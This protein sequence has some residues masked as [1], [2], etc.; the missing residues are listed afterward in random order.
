[1]NQ[2]V[3]F[4]PNA[5]KYMYAYNH[6]TPLPSQR[7]L[8][9]MV[10][11]NIYRN[12]AK[13]YANNLTSNE[14]VTTILEDTTE[15]WSSISEKI[16]GVA[17]M[18]PEG[19]YN[20]STYLG[21]NKE[22]MLPFREALEN[23]QII[24]SVMEWCREEI[25]EGTKSVVRSEDPMS[26]KP[27][28]QDVSFAEKV[29]LSDENR[30]IVIGDVHGGLHTFVEI[31]NSLYERGILK[32]DFGL[33]KGYHVIFLG[34]LVDRGVHSLDVL[35]LVFRLKTR[36]IQSVHIINGNHEDLGTYSNYGFK[37]ELESQ[38]EDEGD[39]DIV[40]NLL[41]YLPTV[42]FVRISNKWIQF[43]H[44][45]ID[46]EYN[47]RKF[48]VSEFD[49]EYHGYDDPIDLKY[50]GLRW[51]DFN[52]NIVSTKL[53]KVRGQNNTR[54]LEYG[55]VSTEKYLEENSL[56]GIVR[57]HQDFMSVGILP[58]ME[59]SMRDFGVME[60]EGMLYPDEFHWTEHL[61]VM[62]ENETVWEHI[63]VADAF[64]DFSV[65]TTS[66]AVKNKGVSHHTYL[67]I[68][69]TARDI[70]KYQ[71]YIRG[72]LREYAEYTR[73]QGV[74]RE[75][76][77]LIHDNIGS[78]GSTFRSENRTKWDRF[79]LWMKF[80]SGNKNFPLLVLDS[81]GSVLGS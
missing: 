48:I 76:L 21:R 52:G 10:S 4:E 54:I 67:E 9:T 74:D 19:V 11:V 81:L 5:P 18:T 51:N 12:K 69:S 72:R 26:R 20:E 62:D 75:F 32:E 68:G 25:N 47:P 14:N 60:G 7:Y 59:G 22:F 39:R 15:G 44:G 40:H 29:E 37:Q 23:Y 3:T 41:T 58:R 65:F 64:R 17:D 61:G 2:T 36:N 42:I 56:S 80:N 73:I 34:D 33:L 38:I 1:M 57:G 28:R 63:S 43:N 8:N 35:H 53:S 70:K 30:I 78:G 49:M 31:M 27:H 46:P 24:Y 71:R 79:V 66:T 50:M 77:H 13:Q 16:K 45:G 6:H 55:P